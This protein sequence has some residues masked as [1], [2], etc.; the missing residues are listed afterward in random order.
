MSKQRIR[1]AM[2]LASRSQL[3]PTISEFLHPALSQLKGI[4]S[5]AVPVVL[6]GTLWRLHRGFFGFSICDTGLDSN[7]TSQRAGQACLD[8]HILTRV[9]PTTRPECQGLT[10]IAANPDCQIL[11]AL[12][13]GRWWLPP[14]VITST[15]IYSQLT[16]T[17]GTF[18]DPRPEKLLS[19]SRPAFD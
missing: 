3:A 4:I 8:K 5:Q 13:P 7:T 17:A 1:K 11:D 16:Q 14:Q 12:N 15:E 10:N 18:G 6:T 19:S 2:L 9:D